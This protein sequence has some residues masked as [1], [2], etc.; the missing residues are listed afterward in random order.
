M[1][2]PHKKYSII[3]ADPPYKYRD[4]PNSGKRGAFHKYPLMTI[5]Q[6]CDL[7]VNTIT[8]EDCWLF[9]WTTWPMLKDYEGDVFD[10]INSWGFKFKTLGFIWV[11][12][13]SQ[14][15]GKLFMGMGNYSR[16]NTEPVLLATKGSPKRVNKGV[17]SVVMSPRDVGKRK[18]S[19]KPDEVRDRIVK[20][21]G[22]IDKIELFARKHVENWDSWGFDV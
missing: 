12:T 11:K 9:I 8:R 10:V 17:H 16:S 6:I 5:D 21:C 15:N 22:D 1:S 18:H 3:Y 19:E 4:R 13:V 2:F 20:L 14:K 7:P